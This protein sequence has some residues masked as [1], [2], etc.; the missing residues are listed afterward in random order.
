MCSFLR[1][2]LTEECATKYY[3]CAT[4]MDEYVTPKGY[5]N[6]K[7]KQARKRQQQVVEETLQSVKQEVIFFR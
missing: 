4:V 5:L 7:I 3:L 1:Y 6:V 2:P